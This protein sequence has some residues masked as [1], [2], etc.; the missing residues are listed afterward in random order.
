MDAANVT[1]YEDAELHRVTEGAVRPGGLALTDR[2]ITLAGLPPGARILDLGCG[3]GTTVRRLTDRHALAA[4]GVDPSPTLVRAGRER[5][6]GLPLLQGAAERLPLADGSVD[7]V[8]SECVLSVVADP[9]RALAELARVLRPAGRLI[10]TD[11][12]ARE[13]AGTGVLQ[14]LPASSC[15]RGATGREELLERVR[16]A[17]FQP[18]GWEDHSDAL[19]RLA[20]RL[21]WETGTAAQLWCPGSGAADI[22][23]L[24]AAVRR[25][26]PGYFLLLADLRRR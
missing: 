25:A 15:L 18:T 11:L 16:R 13:P 20:V 5:W 23:T 10:L 21:V 3:S 26:R 22:A 8:L 7:A 14:A 2:A 9:D 4:I 12:Y 1:C 19:T 24:R 17:G 6:P